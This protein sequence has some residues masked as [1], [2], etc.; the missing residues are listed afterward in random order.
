MNIL[1][2][3]QTIPT[4]NSPKCMFV[5]YFHP[6]EAQATNYAGGVHRGRENYKTFPSSY[7]PQNPRVT[8][9]T[10]L[11]IS[12]DTNSPWKVKK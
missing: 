12:G 4:R 8:V 2:I 5:Q 10:A 7:I 11:I 6:Y 1:T 3:L 9:V